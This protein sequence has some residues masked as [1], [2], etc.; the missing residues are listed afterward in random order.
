MDPILLLRYHQAETTPQE[1]AQVEAWL[2]ESPAHRQELEEVL[3]LWLHAPDA[4]VFGKID[5][6]ADWATLKAKAAER[7]LIEPTKVR[8]LYQRY[9]WLVAA[10]V[11]LLFLVVG[12]RLFI[13]SRE[14]N[15]NYVHQSTTDGTSTLRL[16]DGTQVF[17]NRNSKL[18]FPEIFAGAERVVRIEGEAFFEVAPNPDQPFVVLTDHSR[19]KVLG[20]AFNLRAYADEATE[21]LSVDHG[22]VVFGSLAEAS[23][24]LILEANEQAQ[25]RIAESKVESLPAVSPNSFAWKEQRLQFLA[26]PLQQVLADMEAYYQQPISYAPGS[27]GLGCRLTADWQQNSLKDALEE[28]E[29]VLEL[30]YEFRGDSLLILGADCEAEK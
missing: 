26:T 24:G 4:Q 23:E 6:Q 2:A 13:D 18:G 3:K 15:R 10:S 12:I 14:V 21:V 25:L 27:T 29:A 17:L 11:G 5:T 30:R 22:R 19:T 28:L 1:Q 8:P 7:G 20:T 16:S 9:A